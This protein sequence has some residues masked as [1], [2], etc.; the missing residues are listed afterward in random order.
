M[1]TYVPFVSSYIA[2][3]KFFLFYYMNIVYYY[4]RIFRNCQCKLRKSH[5][6]NLTLKYLYD[7][8]IKSVFTQADVAELADALDLGSSGRPCRFDSCHPHYNETTVVF[9]VV[10]L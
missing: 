8:I 2:S 4:S 1:P 7:N 10:F 3:L 5:R 6:K 9:A